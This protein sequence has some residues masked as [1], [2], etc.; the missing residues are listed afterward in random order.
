MDDQSLAL[1]HEP[2]LLRLTVGP[3]RGGVEGEVEVPQEGAEQE[4]DLGVCEA[5]MGG[6][7]LAFWVE[8]GE[9]VG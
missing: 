3:R 6:G 4:A 8:G 7:G 1:P 2:S 9:G 5:G